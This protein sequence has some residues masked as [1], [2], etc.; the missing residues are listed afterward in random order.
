MR[1]GQ[2][3]GIQ[4]HVVSDATTASYDIII[5]Y[6]DCMH[7]SYPYLVENDCIGEMWV[8]EQVVNISM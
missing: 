8:L 5:S 3:T 4:C 7:T 6:D 1:A 2:A